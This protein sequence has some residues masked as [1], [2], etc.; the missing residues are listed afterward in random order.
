MKKVFIHI[1]QCLLHG[2]VEKV[3]YDIIN[4]LPETDYDVTVLSTILCK[5]ENKTGIYKRGV[6]RKWIYYDCYSD[7]KI[8]K[9]LEILHNGIYHRILPLLLKFFRYDVAIAAQEGQYAVFVKKYVRAKKKLLWIHNDFS[10][11][12]HSKNAFSS[13]EEEEECYRTYDSVVCV[14]GGVMKSMEA[15][16]PKLK[17]MCIAYNPINTYDIDRLKTESISNVPKRPLLVAVGRL[18]EQKSYDRLIAACTVLNG[19]GMEYEVWILGEGE[20]R[21]KLE[22]MISSNQTKNVKL[23]GNQTN[24]YKYMNVADCIINTSRHEGF[25]LVL[26]EATWLGKPIITTKN[27]GAEELL[28]NSEFGVIVGQT[29]TEITDGM[30]MFI[31][32]NELRAHYAEKALERRDFISFEKRIDKI[33]SLI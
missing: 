29:Q 15:M 12:H 1:H 3:F 26:H 8:K 22:D 9:L 23:L 18:A 16:F 32:D 17:N 13:I 30:R 14:S 4:S 25:C 31:K 28:G 11:T 7:D 27:A 19:E 24:P 20:C 5:D 2:G 21:K 10:V 6:H 33:K